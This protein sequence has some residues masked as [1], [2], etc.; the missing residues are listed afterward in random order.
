MSICYLRYRKNTMLI[1]V[2]L[3]VTLVCP[4]R[5]NI[6]KLSS[7]EL[8][9]KLLNCH[10]KLHLINHFQARVLLTIFSSYSN[11]VSAE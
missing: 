8:V 10:E 2:T 1:Y 4:E 3:I 9:I 7:E 6:V 11:I 5:K